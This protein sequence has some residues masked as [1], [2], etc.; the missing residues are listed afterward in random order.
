MAYRP[1][2]NGLEQRVANALEDT[3]ELL[4]GLIADESHPAPQRVAWG[5]QLRAARA[6]LELLYANA[7]S[8]RR[9]RRHG[10]ED[11]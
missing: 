10:A 9:S 5:H 1:Q 6:D 8:T 3:I 7:A 4:G 11:D 2:L